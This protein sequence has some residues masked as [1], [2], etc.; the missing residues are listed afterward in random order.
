MVDRPLSLFSSMLLC[1]LFIKL[2]CFFLFFFGLYN[3]IFYEMDKLIHYV[4]QVTDC[5]ICK[6]GF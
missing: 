1:D 2:L 4:N 3:I 5:Y 6:D